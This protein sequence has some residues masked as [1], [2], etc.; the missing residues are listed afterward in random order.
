MVKSMRIAA[1]TVLALVLGI[2]SG[3]YAEVKS[4]EI[5]PAHSSADF[6]VKHLGVSNVR[7][8]FTDI[9]GII[10]LDDANPTGSSVKVVIK[11][12]SVDTN[13][14]KR[15]D[16]LRTDDFLD[17]AKFPEMS[18]E[19]TEIKKTEDDVFEVTGKFNLHGVEKLITVEVEKVGEGDDPWGGYRVGFE[20]QFE[21]SRKDY[22]MGKLYPVVGDKVKITFSC[23]AV[24]K[25]EKAQ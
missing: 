24:M 16:H 18:F 8:V 12:D 25:K 9:E 22:D 6:K 11:T 7:G 10:N 3:S 14:K 23:E 21:I 20:T 13:N 5:D 4:F 1:I 19:S 2:A 15:D 17:V